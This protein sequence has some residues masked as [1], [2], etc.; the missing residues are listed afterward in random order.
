ME[1][2]GQG[3]VCLTRLPF[4]APGSH[5][6]PTHTYTDNLP[7]KPLPLALSPP[8]PGQRQGASLRFG[9]SDV[10]LGSGKW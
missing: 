9:P 2:S 1:A 6:S 3:K 10:M 4:R 5:P 7:L 8:A